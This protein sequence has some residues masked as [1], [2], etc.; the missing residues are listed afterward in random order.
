MKTWYDDFATHTLTLPTDF[1]TTA[2]DP[3]NDQ[4]QE[5]IFYRCTRSTMIVKCILGGISTRSR[6]TL[7]TK[8]K[9]FTWMDNTTGEYNYNEPIILNIS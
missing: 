9:E 4:A 2:I 3:A 5:P 6:K 8:K 7:F 1:T